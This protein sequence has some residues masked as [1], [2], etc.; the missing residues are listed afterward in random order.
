ML[1]TPHEQERLMVA[2]NIEALAEEA[3]YKKD[4][5]RDV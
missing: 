2:E 5:D 4:G 3:P 1:L